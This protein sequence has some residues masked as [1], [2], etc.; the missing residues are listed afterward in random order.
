[1]DAAKRCINESCNETT[2]FAAWK[3]FRDQSQGHWARNVG[4]HA[5]ILSK[6]MYVPTIKGVPQLASELR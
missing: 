2:N 3:G 6:G 4:V 1:M 5:K